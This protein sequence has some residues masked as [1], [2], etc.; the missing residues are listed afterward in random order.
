MEQTVSWLWGTENSSIYIPLEANGQHI[1]PHQ[2]ALF[3]DERGIDPL[4]SPSTLQRE[5]VN[6][7][8]S[9]I[10]TFNTDSLRGEKQQNNQLWLNLNVL[11]F[12]TFL[13]VRASIF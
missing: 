3:D 7:Q 13:H 10:T 8:E 12:K 2:I 9:C 11:H 5:E 4:I 6:F 1:T